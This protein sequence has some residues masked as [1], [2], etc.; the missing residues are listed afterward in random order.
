MARVNWIQWLAFVGLGIDF[1][2]AVVVAWG[3]FFV[4]PEV[5]ARLG[6]SRIAGET[7]EDHLRLPA[8]QAILAEARA[9][10]YGM[11]LVGIGFLLQLLAAWPK[12]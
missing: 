5:A 2:G 6:V 11:I 12:S 8:V 7:L 3:A 9:T 4:T 10:K 1:I